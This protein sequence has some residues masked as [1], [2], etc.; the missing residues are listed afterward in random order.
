MKGTAYLIVITGLAVTSVPVPAQ[1]APPIAK[2][3][4]QQLTMVE[5]ELVP[6]AEAL[7]AERF[8]FAPARGEF[9]RVRTYGRLHGQ[10]PY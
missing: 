3:F 8:H 10:A 9:A 6:L 1:T 4:D 7:P 5:R 2:I